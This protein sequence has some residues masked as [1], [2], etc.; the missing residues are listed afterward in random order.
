MKQRS[1][2]VIQ[3]VF[4]LIENVWLTEVSNIRTT[5]GG[6]EKKRKDNNKEEQ[7]NL[8]RAPFQVDWRATT[9][10]LAVVGETTRGPTPTG[11][12]PLM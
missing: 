6:V 8:V 11:T 4:H 2:E 7:S 1:P 5:Q 3:E 12:Y 10:A 9:F